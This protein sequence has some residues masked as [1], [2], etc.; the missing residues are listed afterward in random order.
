[1]SLERAATI[2]RALLALGPRLLRE[3]HGEEMEALFLDHLS[4]AH[5][6][7]LLARA[8]V[9]HCAIWDLVRASIA[10]RLTRRARGPHQPEERGLLM[11]GPDLR[12]TVRW[13]TRQ[14]FSTALVVS[15]LALGIAAN[16][17]VFGL[18]NGLFLRPFP[19]PN[20]DRLVYF[21]ETA[22]KWNL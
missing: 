16:V 8:R 4:Q 21:N 11:I 1:M 18:L 22:P 20:P 15:M 12:Y 14:K 3:R 17:V 6:G 10:Q 2:Y 19:F 9:W 5:A 7:G 13:L